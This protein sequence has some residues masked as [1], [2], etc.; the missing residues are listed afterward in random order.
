[1]SVHI[2]PGPWTQKKWATGITSG[3]EITLVDHPSIV[4][5]LWAFHI[6]W[7]F[8]WTCRTCCENGWSKPFNTTISSCYSLHD[9][10]QIVPIYPSSLSIAFNKN[11]A[12]PHAPK[13]A[14][15]CGPALRQRSSKILYKAGMKDSC[16]RTIDPQKNWGETALKV[17]PTPLKLN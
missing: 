11:L 16:F 17:E 7:D 13:N 4:D 14:R 1:M 3:M 10:F 5:G 9:V 12:T 6:P 15:P 2:A 8:P